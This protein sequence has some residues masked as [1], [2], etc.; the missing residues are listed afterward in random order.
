MD[1]P[2]S[3]Q[4]FK[5]NAS[6]NGMI[7]TDLLIDRMEAARKRNNNI[8]MD[9]L[10]ALHRADPDEFRRLAKQIAKEDSGIKDIWDELGQ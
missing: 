8:W 4:T 5:P 3:E 7:D 1:Q 2:S 6:S 9:V 10:R